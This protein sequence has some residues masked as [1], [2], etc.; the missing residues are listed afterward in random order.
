MEGRGQEPPRDSLV[1]AAGS[2]DLT[3][4]SGQ[5]ATCD[6]SMKPGLPTTGQLGSKGGRPFYALPLEVTWCLLLEAVTK[7]HPDSREGNMPPHLVEETHRMKSMGLKDT[8]VQPPRENAT[9]CCVTSQDE[10][11]PK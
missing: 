6:F 7:V 8:V 9:C 2:Q 4:G 3:E 5:E 1:H 10:E 11:W